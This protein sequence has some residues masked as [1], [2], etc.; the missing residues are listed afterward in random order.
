LAETSQADYLITGDEDLLAIKE[1][2]GTKIVRMRE[3]LEA[4]IR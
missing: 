3:F 1:F 4:C 2:G